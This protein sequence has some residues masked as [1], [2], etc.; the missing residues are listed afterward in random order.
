MCPIHNHI[1]N[2]IR[3]WINW[4]LAICI[5]IF[6]KFS[7]WKA[8]ANDCTKSS[9]NLFFAPFRMHETNTN[10]NNNKKLFSSIFV[11]FLIVPPLIR[12]RNQ[13]L[14]AFEGGSVSLEC[15]VSKSASF[16]SFEHKSFCIAFQFSCL[17]INS[18]LAKSLLC[19]FELSNT[20]WMGTTEKV[21]L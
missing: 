5:A 19:S 17:A 10:Y 9:F 13:Y 16:H 3:L 12:V 20:F 6:N 8:N 11:W 4:S 7:R 18:F 1:F 2:Q 15:E 14:Y 21:S